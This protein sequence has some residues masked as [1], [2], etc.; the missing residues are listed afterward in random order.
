[1]IDFYSYTTNNGYRV[2]IMLEE[3]ELPYK[4]HLIDLSHGK[5]KTPDFL[6]IN[7][8]GKIPAI[9]DHD[10]ARPITVFES[11]AILLYLSEKT[12]KFMPKTAAQRAEMWQWQMVQAT[13]L[14]PM[15]GQLYYFQHYSP[16]KP[17]FALKRYSDESMRLLT[18]ADQHLKGRT[19]F[20]GDELTLADIGWIPV[21]AGVA[22]YGLKLDGLDH[23][24][25]WCDHMRARPAVQKGMKL[26][27]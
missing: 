21:V 10:G 7:P 23:L 2:G 8:N 16:E 13:G 9:V 26:S 5:Q 17:E 1:M 14:S 27:T 19:Y 4:T 20:V 25:K 24:Q 18:L 12:G 6:A 15:I 3:C 22:G 11:A